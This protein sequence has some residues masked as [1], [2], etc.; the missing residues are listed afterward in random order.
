MLQGAFNH[1]HRSSTSVAPEETAYDEGW[2]HGRI[3]A[4]PMGMFSEAWT[5][6]DFLQVLTGLELAI[7]ELYGSLV[8]LDDSYAARGL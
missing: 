5:A 7:L 4:R 3:S 8:N 2:G 6:Y 1:V